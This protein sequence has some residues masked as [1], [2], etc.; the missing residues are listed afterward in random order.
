M[1]AVL[2][3]MLLAQ[4]PVSVKSY[5]SVP[6]TSI[7]HYMI[8]FKVKNCRSTLDTLQTNTDNL[9]AIETIPR[10]YEFGFEG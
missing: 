9:E 4:K 7:L 2:L 3:A 1:P 8:Q 5:Q 6:P 10:I